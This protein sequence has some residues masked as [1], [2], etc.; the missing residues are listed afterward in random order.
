MEW[1]TKKS[2]QNRPEQKLDPTDFATAATRD[3]TWHRRDKIGA[4]QT[5]EAGARPQPLKG[6]QGNARGK[7][8]LRAPLVPHIPARIKQKLFRG[9]DASGEALGAS[10]M[11]GE[12]KLKGMHPVAYASRKLSDLE[13]KYLATE[14]ECLKVL[15][16]LKYFRYYIWGMTLEVVTKPYVG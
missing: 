1:G 12:K 15:W 8:G 11:Q 14:R 10:L 2:R 16:A 9:L 5:K 13:K 3:A 7:K 4:E 6:H